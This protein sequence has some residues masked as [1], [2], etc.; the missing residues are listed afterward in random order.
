MIFRLP[1]RST[2]S[3][4]NIAGIAGFAI[5]PLVME[6]IPFY[7]SLVVTKEEDCGLLSQTHWQ[8]IVV[9][10]GL[11]NSLTGNLTIS[12]YP[13]LQSIAIKEDSLNNLQ[14]LTIANNP[15]LTHININEVACK[16]IINLYINSIYDLI[17]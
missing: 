1:I 2:L 16:Y 17:N 9:E 4:A 7:Q 12:A 8:S 5:R 10:Q 11:C 6:T 13:H 15:L 3:D 14:S